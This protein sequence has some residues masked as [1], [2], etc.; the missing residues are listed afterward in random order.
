MGNASSAKVEE[1]INRGSDPV[2]LLDSTPVTSL[3]NTTGT[4]SLCISPNDEACEVSVQIPSCSDQC[5]LMVKPGTLMW[6]AVLQACTR[7]RHSLRSSMVLRTSGVKMEWCCNV[8]IQS[9][10]DPQVVE[11]LTE[12]YASNLA[13]LDDVNDRA[14]EFAPA[15]S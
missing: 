4:V 10:T 7:L 9:Q 1:A 12:H 14:L 13:S 5:K 11:L 8:E 6:T 3:G 15:P 2:Y